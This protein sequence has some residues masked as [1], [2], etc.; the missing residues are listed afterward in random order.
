MSKV[1]VLDQLVPQVEQSAF[2]VFAHED[3]SLLQPY[4]D[5]IK[6]YAAGIDQSVETK[7]QQDNLRS[8]AHKITRIKTALAKI[9]ADESKRVKEI[10]RQ[11]DANRRLLNETLDDLQKQVR[12]PL[13]EYEEKEEARIAKIKSVITMFDEMAAECHLY[14]IDELKA[15]ISKAQNYVPDF[16]YNDF[17]L[18]LDDSISKCSKTLLQT[19][20][21]KKQAEAD[22]LELERLRAEAAENERLAQIEKAKQ[23]AAEQARLQAERE[24][25][26]KLEAERLRIRQIELDAQAQKE[27]QQKAL[28]DA[29]AARLQAIED[30]RIQAENAENERKLALERAEQERLQAIEDERQRIES[31]R[32]AQENEA[33]QREADKQ[34]KAKI[35]NEALDDIMKADGSI[36][37]DQAKAIVTFIAQKKVRNV[38]IQY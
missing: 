37:A 30:A 32:L 24:A 7:K 6:E 27:A 28:D 15:A 12:Q 14:S 5:Q 34:H 33:R 25:E 20:E 18:Q 4:V 31:E 13:T 16:S 17:A 1:I 19:L 10:P 29:E 11:I 38:S 26:Q 35:H 2:D 23:E 9:G 3:F 22:R 36:T 8:E 21:Q